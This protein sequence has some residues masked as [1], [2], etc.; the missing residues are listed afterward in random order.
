MLEEHVYQIR[1][2]GDQG[3]LAYIVDLQANLCRVS[4]QSSWVLQS[5]NSWSSF[6][7]VCFAS[8]RRLDQ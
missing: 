2:L 1:D 8:D 4:S 5:N 3:G 6:Q 7:E